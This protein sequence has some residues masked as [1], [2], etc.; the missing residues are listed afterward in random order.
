MLIAVKQENTLAA[1][2]PPET[3]APQASPARGPSRRRSRLSTQAQQDWHNTESGAMENR[4]AT[5]G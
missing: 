5:G 2:R 3:P 1:L 4:D